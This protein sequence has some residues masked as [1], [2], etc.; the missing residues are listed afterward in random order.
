MCNKTTANSTFT[1]T[2]TA[3]AT[4]TELITTTT[5]LKN[6]CYVLTFPRYA[7]LINL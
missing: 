4:T 7:V 2:S 6:V 1:V 5:T 3:D